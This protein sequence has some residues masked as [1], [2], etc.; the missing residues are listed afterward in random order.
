MNNLDLWP[1]KPSTVSLAC[2]EYVFNMSDWRE[3]ADLWLPTHFP[4]GRV[5]LMYN[6]NVFLSF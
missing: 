6:P 2:L 4:S 5:V 1:V 3:S